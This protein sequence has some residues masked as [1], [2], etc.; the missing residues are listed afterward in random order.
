MKEVTRL[1]KAFPL[2]LEPIGPFKSLKESERIIMAW[3]NFFTRVT[4]VAAY[5][6]GGE[7]VQAKEQTE[8]GKFL[9]WVN[10]TFPFSRSHATRYMRLYEWFKDDPAVL[11]NMGVTEALRRAGIIEPKKAL[12]DKRGPIEYGNPNKQVELPW[13]TI[14]AK[15]PIS[16]AKLKN[17]RVECIGLHDIYLVSK[18]FNFPIKVVDLILENPNSHLKAPYQGMLDSIQAALE[19]YYAE[20]ERLEALNK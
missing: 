3:W 13:E 9:K 5:K 20:V 16:K 17:Y 2:S 6:M 19:L 14:F 18:G 7:L 15:Q 12:P 4:A 10:D 8:H 1:N 11:E